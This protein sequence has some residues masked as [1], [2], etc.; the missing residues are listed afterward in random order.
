MDRI[1]SITGKA[2]LKQKV[3]QIE[4]GLV[5]D[6][7]DKDYQKAYQKAA[8]DLKQLQEVLQGLGFA[9]DECKTQ[10]FNVSTEY[11]SQRDKDG[12]YRDV[13]KGYRLSH[14]LQLTFPFDPIRLNAV[15]AG[16]SSLKAKPQ[17]N[18]RFT[19]ADKEACRKQ[20]LKKAAADAR[21]K[22]QLLSE[23]LGAQLAEIMEIRYENG[24]YDF[25]S[26]TRYG[27]GAMLKNARAEEALDAMSFAPE[28]VRISDTVSCI[29]K[30][31]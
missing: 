26:P 13:F 16:I 3:D 22:A 24:G 2:S 30:L 21:Q 4:M 12:N 15:L 9:E 17:L 19:V 7:L 1:I 31:Q 8:S 25:Y 20:L 6:K 27:T 5:L 18:V 23:E 28:D 14:S 11:E 29:W 10:D